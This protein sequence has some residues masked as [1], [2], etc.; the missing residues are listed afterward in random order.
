MGRPQE[1]P[2]AQFQVNGISCLLQCGRPFH[3]NEVVEGQLLK[4]AETT[5]AEMSNHRQLE[6]WSSIYVCT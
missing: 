6:F 5:A 1:A 3:T 2:Q 4:V